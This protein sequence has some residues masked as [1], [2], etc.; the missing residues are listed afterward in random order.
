MVRT[1][2]EPYYFD[3]IRV[4][5][6]QRLLFKPDTTD[7]GIMVTTLLRTVHECVQG[8][9]VAAAENV[10]N[11]VVEPMLMICDS[12]SHTRHCICVVHEPVKLPVRIRERSIIEITADNNIP[13]G[14]TADAV[15]YHSCLDSP[16]RR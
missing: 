2:R 11:T 10:V 14:L 9:Y 12:G 6:P 1:A 4:T 15:S 13:R 7:Y 16:L 8:S 3:S 5:R